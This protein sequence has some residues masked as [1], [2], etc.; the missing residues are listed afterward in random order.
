MQC[1]AAMQSRAHT[2][3]SHTHAL[4]PPNK[5]CAYSG[6]PE[7]VSC[8]H[9]LIYHHPCVWVCKVGCHCNL[10]G[11]YGVYQVGKLAVRLVM[12]S[13][14]ITHNRY[15]LRQHGACKEQSERRANCGRVYATEE[16]R[17]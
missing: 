12:C 11:V 10:V 14:G 4:P 6:E 2:P 7:V 13:K 16:L 17:C 1:D 8:Q 3:F 9:I 15:L 5:V